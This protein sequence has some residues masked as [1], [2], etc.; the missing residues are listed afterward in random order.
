MKKH[1]VF[2]TMLIALLILGS[3]VSVAYYNTKSFGF[4]EDAVLVKV[5][6][7]SITFLDF[8]IYFSDVKE[9]YNE[10]EKYI[11]DEICTTNPHL[12]ADYE[13]FDIFGI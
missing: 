8:Q 12:I 3:G 2:I 6:K 4:D 1:P 13:L 5:E 10:T 7:D 9:I 11:P